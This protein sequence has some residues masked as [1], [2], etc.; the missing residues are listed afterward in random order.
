MHPTRDLAM[1]A[2]VASL[3]VAACSSSGSPV[4]PGTPIARPS[5]VSSADF[6]AAPV[7]TPSPVNTAS[8]SPSPSATPTPSKTVAPT[9]SARL[10]EQ[11]LLYRLRKDAKVACAPKRVGLPARAIA[12]IEC[13]PNTSLVSLVGVYGF[14]SQRDA[15]QT[16]VE[17]LAGYGVQLRTGDCATGKAGD[18]AWTP[19]DGE[20][21]DV[22]FRVGCFRDSKGIAN[23]RLTCWGGDH[24]G[25]YIGIVGKTSDI[26]ALYR[27]AWRFQTGDGG[28]APSSPGI[29][30][31][32]NV[33]GD[34]GPD[35]SFP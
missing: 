5:A 20:S 3:L 21:G 8:V 2:L 12:A 18:E 9:S 28:Y 19:G 32:N 27:W 30:N 13:G 29:C 4:P 7:A 15:L 16:Y 26:G 6:S 31:D 17:R 25:V 23:I 34:P 33:A 10:I 14:R 1:A 24:G 22:V 11:D 35:P